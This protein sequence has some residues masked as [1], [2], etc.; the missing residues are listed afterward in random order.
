MRGPLAQLP[1]P[2]Q[3][4]YERRPVLWQ[5][6][7]IIP[8]VIL[9]AV[10]A[11]LQ[12]DPQQSRLF[13]ALPF[14]FVGLLALLRWPP[15]GLIILVSASLAFPQE[16]MWSIGVTTI[17]TMGL[18]GLWLFDMIARRRQV[19]FDY[20]PVYTPFIALIVV[21]VI[22]FG[23]GQLPWFPVSAAPIDA[24]VGGILIYLV[25]FF[26][27]LLI[28]HHVRDIRWLKAITFIFIGV[29]G[30]Y[31]VGQVVPPVGQVMNR[32]YSPIVPAH[33]MFWT[34]LVALTFGIGLFDQKLARHWRGMLL[35]IGATALYLTLFETRAW[36]SGWMPA[37][38]ALGVIVWVGAPKIASVLS[39]AGLLGVVTQLDVIL[40]NFL[41][42]GDNAYSE[43]TR[44]EAW[45]II[46]EIVQVNP[47]F[48]LGPANYSSYTPLF[49]IFGWFVRFN[50]HNNYID[51]LAQ[52]GVLGLICFLWLIWEVG[53]LTWRLL[54]RVRERDD[55]VRAYVYGA[56][57]GFVAT[58][59]S[60][61]LGD[62]V[63]PYVYNITIRGMRASILPWLFFGGLIA[64]NHILDHQRKDESLKREPIA[65][66]DSSRQPSQPPG[67]HAHRRQLRAEN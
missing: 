44:L 50:S 26:A 48:G 19:T 4:W 6:L 22:A 60:G 58:M 37:L 36:A 9:L 27:M 52:T 59:A 11:V 13:M 65:Q 25:A 24:Q 63:L 39:L 67:L 40:N 3:R 46:L 41:Y 38:I 28:A 42:V 16:I 56:A 1:E 17:M 35:G 30:A 57:G 34:W 53:K 18:T 31:V 33:S 23:M 7:I 55:F 64:I 66:T 5:R 51:V 10:L 54:Q 12:L 14:A 32:L 62:W 2:I 21:S 15:L 20:S 29:G 47:L 45:R 43:A 8:G 61:V 49:P